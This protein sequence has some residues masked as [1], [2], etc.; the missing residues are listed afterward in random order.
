MSVRTIIILLALPLFLLLA[1][2]NSLLLYRQEVADVEQGLR[3][4][5]LAAAVTVAEFA[6]VARDP[7]AELGAPGRLAAVRAA[8]ARIPGLDALYLAAPDGR[9]LNLLHRPAIVRYSLKAPP[10]PIIIGNWRD[11]EAQPLI[12]A[13]APAGRDYVAVADIDAR[14]LVRRAFHLKRLSIALVAGSAAL[15]ILLGLIVA[16]RVAREFRRVR[17]IA[18]ARGGV[19]TEARLGIGEVR[20]LAAAIGLIDKSVVAELERLDHHGAQGIEAGIRAMRARHLPDLSTVRNGIALSIRALSDAGPGAF[21]LHR[22]T[23]DGGCTVILGEV[24]G[25][26]ATA[27]ASAMALTAYV[28]AGADADF[29]RRAGAAMAAYGCGSVRRATFASMPLALALHD[30][31]GAAAAYLDR[32]PELDADALTAD[33]AVLLPKAGIVAAMRAA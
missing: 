33:L 2:V 26:P 5:A 12:A 29:E 32:N 14:P 11:N 9:I 7:I 8:G 20:D 23:A 3:G 16:A 10:R 13:R 15:A 17:S 1:G 28:Q 6:R 31:A 22:F 24:P 4:E 19:A 18:A 27:F 21:H 25:E 30:A